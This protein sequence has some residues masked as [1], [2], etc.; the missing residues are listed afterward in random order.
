LYDLRGQLPVKKKTRTM[1]CPNPIA[2]LFATDRLPN[3]AP[4]THVAFLRALIL[5]LA[6]RLPHAELRLHF[7]VQLLD[8]ESRLLVVRDE[9]RL[10][11]DPLLLGFGVLD[12]RD[13][14]GSTCSRHA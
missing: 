7:P 12:L 2:K 1:T 8:L 9:E 11:D 13:G 14:G 3:S 6:Y 10:D 4:Y 5:A